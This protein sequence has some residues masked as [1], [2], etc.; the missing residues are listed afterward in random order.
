M[1]A[2]KLG[3]WCSN[4]INFS[5]NPP[6]AL[7]DISPKGETQR[8]KRYQKSVPP[9]LWGGGTQSIGSQIRTERRRPDLEI[10]E[11]AK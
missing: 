1:C 9:P 3:N 8:R 7:R 11:P 2:Q 5:E 4:V 6:L 10:N